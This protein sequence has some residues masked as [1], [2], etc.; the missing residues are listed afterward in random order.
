M[1]EFITPNWNAPLN[2]HAVTTTRYGGYSTAPYDSCNLA[3]HVGDLPEIVAKNRALLRA[4]LHLPS[5]PIWLQQVHGIETVPAI[6]A[7]HNRCADASYSNQ[8]GQVCV[9]M[10]ADCLP[11]L[12]CDKAGTRVAA[13]HAGWRGLVAGILEQTARTLNL[14]M[15]EILVWLGPGIGAQA[16]EVGD[17]VRDIFIAQLPES[18]QAFIPSRPQHWFADLYLLARQRLQQLGIQAIFGG[19]FCT[20]TESARFYS[21]RRD[22]VTGRMATLIWLE[23]V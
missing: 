23:A 11:V 16:F 9:I 2:V 15:D 3:L 12:F 13:A 22:Q 5:E 6:V 7:N 18:S 20:Y 10:T 4:E 19:N 21:Y 14:P 1:L 8:P 17:E